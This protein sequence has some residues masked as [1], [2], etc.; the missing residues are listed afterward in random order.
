[1]KDILYYVQLYQIVTDK[2]SYNAVKKHDIAYITALTETE[3]KSEF[4]PTKYIPYL[5]LTSELWDVFCEYLAGDK[6]RHN[7]TTLYLTNSLI[8]MI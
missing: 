8:K 2:Y 1:M 5:A 3:Y 6:P 7:G 4:E